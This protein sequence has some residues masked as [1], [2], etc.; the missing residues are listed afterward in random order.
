[1][2]ALKSPLRLEPQPIFLSLGTALL[3]VLGCLTS[4]S[5]AGPT[6]ESLRQTKIGDSLCRD[7][8][9]EDAEGAYRK[10]LRIF[11]EA[12][13]ARVGLICC[14]FASHNLK[15]DEQAIRLIEQM[16]LSKS[17]KVRVLN[18]APKIYWQ[19]IT[20]YIYGGRI[21]GH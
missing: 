1:M 6:F 4:W 21:E 9:F 20:D 7:Q 11:P 18:A 8:R 13:E 17:Q 15:K 3:L 16:N 14:L 10:A 2:E 12:D 19:S 5:L